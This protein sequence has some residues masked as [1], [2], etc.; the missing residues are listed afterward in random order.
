MIC[1]CGRTRPKDK[2]L[3]PTCGE[4][5]L[6][7]LEEFNRRTEEIDEQIKALEEQ[8]DKIHREFRNKRVPRAPFH[9]LDP[10]IQVAEQGCE[11]SLMI[12]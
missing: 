10:S 3:C 4:R 6:Q 8:K 7:D 5:L 1:D 11:L 9:E 12:K 2:L